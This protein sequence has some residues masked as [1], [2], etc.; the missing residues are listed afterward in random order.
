MIALMETLPAALPLILGGLTFAF[1]PHWYIKY[2]TNVKS[3]AKGLR[4]AGWIIVGMATFVA[5]EPAILKLIP[6][7]MK[8]HSN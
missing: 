7:L 8:S 6:L 4:I 3:K 2:P 1:K 5:L